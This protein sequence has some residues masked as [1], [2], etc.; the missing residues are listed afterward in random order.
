MRVAKA[1]AWPVDRPLLLRPLQEGRRSS[2]RRPHRLSVAQMGA[3]SAAWRMESHDDEVT[4]QA[5]RTAR[6]GLGR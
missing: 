2:D 5:A 3:P 6:E 4:R 1:I